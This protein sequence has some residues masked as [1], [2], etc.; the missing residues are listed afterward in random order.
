MTGRTFR[1]IVR[2]MEY[3]T[4][5]LGLYVTI[6]M[7]D[8]MCWN[9][10]HGLITYNLHV[11]PYCLYLKTYPELWQKCIKKQDKLKEHLSCGPFY[12]MCHAGVEEFIYPVSLGERIAG[13]ISVSGYRSDAKKAAERMDNVSRLFSV[14]R[15]AMDEMYH[16]HLTDKVP[17]R[18]YMDTLISPLC[19][20]LELACLKSGEVKKEAVNSKHNADWL[21]V[22]LLRYLRE[23][24][25]PGVRLAELCERYN[26][27]S[28]YISH[29]FK[30]RG[31]MSISA[32]IN[33]L[34]V[35]DAKPLLSGTALSVCDVAVTVGYS[36]ANYFSNVFKVQTGIS[37]LEWRRR[38]R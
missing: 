1:N 6:H 35:E 14:N 15:A 19:D 28:S 5:R 3:L 34:R 2:Y 16:K 13:W 26:C 29:L 24:H 7:N 9:I 23:N 12:G 31:G 18:D 32:F 8:E 30:K 11:N 17:D 25:T 4:G 21:Y 37:P 22:C 27:S 20:M 10:S 33:H 36:D 38:E